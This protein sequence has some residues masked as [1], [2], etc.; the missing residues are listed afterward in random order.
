MN[1]SR[2]EK[3]WAMFTRRCKL[4]RWT[5]VSWFILETL[6]ICL[7]TYNGIFDLV[8]VKWFVVYVLI[9]LLHDWS[10]QLWLRTD[11]ECYRHG[12]YKLLSKLVRHLGSN[13]RGRSWCVTRDIALYDMVV[14][15]ERLKII[16]LYLCPKC[17]YIFGHSSRNIST[18]KCAWARIV[19]RKIVWVRPKYIKKNHV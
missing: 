1:V 16:V 13:L 9:W 4:R 14:Y 17:T 10:N 6:V 15:I 2:L 19:G 11:W 5:W 12:C 7:G 3:P 8:W 18:V